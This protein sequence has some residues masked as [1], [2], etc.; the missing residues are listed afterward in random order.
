[1]SLT[2]TQGRTR[3]TSSTVLFSAAPGL[4]MHLHH[5]ARPALQ[6]VLLT[7]ARIW[8]PACG[9]MLRMTVRPTLTSVGQPVQCSSLNLMG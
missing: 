2:G 5:P 3:S 4:F 9:V 7:R 6:F 1:M 8:R